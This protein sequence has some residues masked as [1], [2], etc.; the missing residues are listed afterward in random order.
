LPGRSWKNDD[1]ACV[2]EAGMTQRTSITDRIPWWASPFGI[3]VVAL[4]IL[5]IV[6]APQLLQRRTEAIRNYVLDVIDP[7]S[8]AASSLQ[9]GLTNEMYSMIGF[10]ATR[11]R[12]YQTLYEASLDQV[13]RSLA[14]LSKL[15]PQLDET[16]RDQ[17][18]ALTNS[19]EKWDQAVQ[20]LGLLRYQ[21]SAD[22]FRNELLQQGDYLRYALEDEANLQVALQNDV[23]VRRE[24]VRRSERMA[25]AVIAALGIFGSVPILLVARL[26]RQLHQA[27]RSRDEALRVVS[28]DLRS[29]LATVSVSASLLQKSELSGEQRGQLIEMIERSSQ[30]MNRLIGDLMDQSRAAVGLPLSIEKREHPIVEVLHEVCAGASLRAKSKHIAITCNINGDPGTIPMDRDRILQAL[31][32]LVDNAIRFTP[33]GGWIRLVCESAVEEVLISVC[34]RGA[35][36]NIGEIQ[37]V[38]SM[39]WQGETT[40]SEGLGLGLPIT[41][42]IVLEHG[43]RIWAENRAEG[44][45]FCFTLPRRVRS[46]ADDDS[47][48]DLPQAL[49]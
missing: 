12:Q 21:Y 24:E 26:V 3:G 13:N 18:Q 22:D 19:L 25:L 43:G 7:A 20:S 30:R 49:P 41:R 32:N 29:P 45:A 47:L 39:Y 44:P 9:I 6:L 11:D 31:T 38:F 40:R 28:H 5:A 36:L 15:S 42:W 14:E 4:I 10:Q 17:L 1:L 23:G 34:N 48:R 46:T 27:I 2:Y 16:S 33:Q 35:R 37:K 8:S